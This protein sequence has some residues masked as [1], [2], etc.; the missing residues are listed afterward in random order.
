MPHG[1]AAVDDGTYHEFDPKLWRRLLKHAGE[2]VVVKDPTDPRSPFV[3]GKDAK[4]ALKQAAQ[5]GFGAPV[6]VRVPQANSSLL[7]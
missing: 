5:Q 6:L 4:A 2:W 3:V 1:A 7:L